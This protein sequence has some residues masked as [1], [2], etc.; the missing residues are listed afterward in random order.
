MSDGV[1]WSCH[2]RSLPIFWPLPLF[3]V[4]YIFLLLSSFGFPVVSSCICT[5]QKGLWPVHI[6][7]LDLW[8]LILCTM[9]WSYWVQLTAAEAAASR[10]KLKDCGCT[11]AVLSNCST[12]LTEKWNRLCLSTCP[13]AEQRQPSHVPDRWF[14]FATNR[15]HSCQSKAEDKCALQSGVFW[16]VDRD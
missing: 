7:E 6:L 3:C 4:W 12:K 11:R 13:K 1:S 2:H 14:W 9:K 16:V 8:T 5:R 10:E 15:Q